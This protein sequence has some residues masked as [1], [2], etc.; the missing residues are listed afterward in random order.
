MNALPCAILA[1]LA[2]V[3]VHAFPVRLLSG[4]PPPLDTA[5]HQVEDGIDHH[6]HIE[7]LGAST[8]LWRRDES[9]DNLPFTAGHIGW[10]E[11]LVVHAPNFSQLWADGQSF[12]DSF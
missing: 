10:V 1:P 7:R 2:K 4:Q 3:M 12:S 6:S 11:L 9:F 5:R 8:R